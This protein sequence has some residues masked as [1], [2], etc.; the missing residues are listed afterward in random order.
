[1]NE[2]KLNE[3]GALTEVDSKDITT[4]KIENKVSLVYY[5]L[6]QMGFLAISGFIGFLF[7]LYKDTNST[8][9]F[10]SFDQS[11]IFGPI[12]IVI[13]HGGNL[14]LSYGIRKKDK[15]ILKKGANIKLSPFYIYPAVFLN[16]VL[17]VFFFL[18]IYQ[19]MVSGNTFTATSRYGVFTRKNAIR[20]SIT[21]RSNHV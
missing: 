17:S 9:P 5:Y 18:S 15:L 6:I 13:T 11:Y 7:G 1:M 21:S 19:L 12:F 14:G 4:N 2:E 10:S 8:Y 20:S 3:V 16:F